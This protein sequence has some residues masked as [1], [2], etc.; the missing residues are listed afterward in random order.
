VRDLP[1]DLSD[2]D[3]QARLDHVQRHGF[4][5][6]FGFQRVGLPSS[7][8]RPHQIGELIV[9]GKWEDAVKKIF[10]PSEFDPPECAR[11]KAAFLA[12]SAD[13]DAA[14]KLIP[15][16]SMQVERSVLTGLKRHGPRAWEAAIR[17]IA[18]ARR[19]MYLHAYQSYLF[20]ELAS[21]R[22]KEYG[23]KVV[24]GDLVR[25]SSE[26]DKDPMVGVASA[27]SAAQLNERLEDPLSCVVLPLPGSNVLYP[28]NNTGD[29]LKQ[30]WRLGERASVCR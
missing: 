19:T 8:V 16:S 11:A 14:L 4:I 25:E 24:E 22:I 5:N 15:P 20:N 29:Y 2:V 12:N 9:A 27:E 26:S 21:F 10:T 6:Y 30:V 23:T 7:A 1:T 17:S 13:V 3:I 28:V 18:F